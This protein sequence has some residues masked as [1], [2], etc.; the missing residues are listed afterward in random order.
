[1]VLYLVDEFLR[2]LHTHTEGERLGLEPPATAC[3][4]F[5]DV[6]GRMTRGEDNGI[7]LDAGAVGC[8]H[9]TYTSVLENQVGYT[10]VEMIFATAFNNRFAHTRNNGRQ[11]VGAD[12]GMDVD[13]DVGVGA[14]F[15]KE[16]QHI[17]HIATLGG[18]SVELA[19]TV[20]SRTSLAEAPVAVGIHLLGSHQVDN[21][22]LAFL[23]RF[24][25]LH[26]NRLHAQLQSLQG[27]K[28]SGRTGTNNNNC[29]R[30]MWSEK[31][32]T[33]LHHRACTREFHITSAQ[34]II[35]LY[36]T[37]VQHIASTAI[38]AAARDAERLQI[39]QTGAQ[40]TRHGTPHGGL[41]GIFL[42]S[43]VNLYLLHALLFHSTFSLSKHS[44]PFPPLFP[45]A[46]VHK[47]PKIL[48][49][50][51]PPTSSQYPSKALPTP[52]QLLPR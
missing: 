22:F 31:R 1:M 21:V 37:M 12:M 14:M 3:K 52:Y 30:R 23:D 29:T 50:L 2:M 44:P 40:S 6:A 51:L 42:R 46:K 49:T 28:E 24:S 33:G 35:Y 5:I 17:A 36:R 41:G 20:C 47:K 48:K 9:S 25:A 18:P 10:G 26:D 27:G 34:P 8:D 11:T 16:T 4:K 7:T 39:P 45:P 38:N 32:R 43:Q 13:H 19:V 15:D